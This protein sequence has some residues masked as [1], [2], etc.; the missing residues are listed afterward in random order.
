MY[1]QIVVMECLVLISIEIWK[2][3]QCK[4]KKNKSGFE[5][6]LLKAR[7]SHSKGRF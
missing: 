6:Y 7:C 5:N 3:N 4:S 1:D 2:L